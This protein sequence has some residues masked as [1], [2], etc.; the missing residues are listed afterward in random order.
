MDEV[1]LLQLA[2]VVSFAMIRQ[3]ADPSKQSFSV[4]APALCNNK[5]TQTKLTATC[6]HHSWRDTE[7]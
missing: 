6:I 1:K 3:A 5:A 2:D 7:Y 4:Q